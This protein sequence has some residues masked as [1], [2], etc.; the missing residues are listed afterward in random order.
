MFNGKELD[1]ETNLSYYGAR[2]LDMKTSLWLN[3]DPL[4][5][6]TINY[7]AY[8]YT[9]NNP[10]R[11]IDPIGMSA[12]PPTGVDAED[13]AVHSDN[14]GTWKY[15]KATTTWKGQDGA[16]DIGNTIE[17]DNVNIKGYKSNYVSSGDYGPSYGCE[18][19]LQYSLMLV[20][21]IAGPILAV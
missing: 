13:G 12:E 7:G 18:K 11:F 5:E 6:K 21:A 19:D 17:L 2:Y 14:S 9:F 1:R 10:I 15:E 8:V 20:G 16:K 4:A 3:V